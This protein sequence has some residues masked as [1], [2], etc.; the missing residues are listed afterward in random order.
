MADGELPQTRSL[1][2]ASHSDWTSAAALTQLIMT[3]KTLKFITYDTLRK[4]PPR[5]AH[6]CPLSPTSHDVPVLLHVSRWDLVH[7]SNII[8]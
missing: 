3:L 2:S 5:Y 6:I 1:A 7:F 8:R 4:M